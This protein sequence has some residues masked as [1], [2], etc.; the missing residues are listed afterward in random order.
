MDVDAYLDRIGAKRP[1]T[2]DGPALTELHERHLAAVPFENLD[3]HLG[4]PIELDEDRL[5]AK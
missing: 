2:V 4:V 1:A 3:I 5:V